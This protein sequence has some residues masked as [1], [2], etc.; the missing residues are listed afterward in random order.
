MLHR[1]V[2]AA[3]LVALLGPVA[4]AAAAEPR[5]AAD[6]QKALQ[7]LDEASEQV[8][9]ARAALAAL[10]AGEPVA[11]DGQAWAEAPAALVAAAEALKRSAGPVLP[12]LEDHVI[13]TR[14]LRSCST[15]TEALAELERRHRALLAGAQRGAEARAQLRDRLTAVHATDEARRYLVKTGAKHA[16]TPALAEVFTWRWTDLEGPASAALATATAELKRWLDRVERSAAEQ[17]ARATEAADLLATYGRAKDC[18]LAGS[19]TGTR[20]L[21]GA[22]SGLGLHLAAAAEVWSGT[23]MVDGASVGVKSVAVNGSAVTVVL[24]DG[25]GTLAGTVSADGRALKGTFSSQDGPSP[26]QLRKQP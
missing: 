25:L 12:E 19:W 20:T 26:F 4:V 15:R 10:D 22:V 3:S 11:E 21:A 13:S 14:Q 6:T 2:W 16:G 7:E 1:L 5:M 18:L 17:R 8:S 9:R 24:V 23:A